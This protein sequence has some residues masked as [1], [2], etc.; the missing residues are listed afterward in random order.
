[1][2]NESAPPV[3]SSRRGKTYLAGVGIS[4]GGTRK[5][6]RIVT[7]GRSRTSEVV[8]LTSGEHESA[9]WHKIKNYP[10]TKTASSPNLLRFPPDF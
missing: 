1:M 10:L 8:L 5:E 2:E 3:L 4:Q 6:L 7:Y 9:A